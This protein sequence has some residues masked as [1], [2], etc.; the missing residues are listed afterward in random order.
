M[1][2]FTDAGFSLD[3]V[4][5][6][7][8]SAR[9]LDLFGKPVELTLSKGAALSV[10][11]AQLKSLNHALK[12][13][14]SLRSL[15]EGSVAKYR[16]EWIAAWGES[17]ADDSTVAEDVW[18]FVTPQLLH[19]PCH[20]ASNGRHVFLHFTIDID[21]EHGVEL[22]LKNEEVAQ[23]GPIECRWQEAGWLAAE[24]GSQQLRCT[25]F[26]VVP[27]TT[28]EVPI[29]DGW[30]H[31]TESYREFLDSWRNVS[32]L[33]KI[34]QSIKRRSLPPDIRIVMFRASLSDEMPLEE[35]REWSN[36]EDI[37]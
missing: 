13:E 32:F 37:E 27:G 4:S 28:L 33:K 30:V 14:E 15:V 10:E 19:V 23:I 5:D 20:Y 3:E 18:R 8:V 24:R 7:W 31:Q 36:H 11:P 22:S 16:R 34:V 17:S 35:Y 26:L 9:S 12:R 1:Q 29:P 21:E 2:T 25:S 6:R